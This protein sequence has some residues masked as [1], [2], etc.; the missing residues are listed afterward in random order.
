MNEKR[1]GKPGHSVSR[2]KFGR[3][4]IWKFSSRFFR[5]KILSRDI[6]LIFIQEI[7]HGGCKKVSLPDSS[8]FDS[9]NF[10]NVATTRFNYLKVTDLYEIVKNREFRI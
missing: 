2:D 9:A 7:Q 1:S 6:C 10:F 3:L 4:F 5:T 8:I